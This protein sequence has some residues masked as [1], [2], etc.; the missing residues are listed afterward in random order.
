M[1]EANFDLTKNRHQ[2]VL[3]NI[4]NNIENKN[5]KAMWNQ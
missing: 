3:F 1:N 2:R 5:T 4:N